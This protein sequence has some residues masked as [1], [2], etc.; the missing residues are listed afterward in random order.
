MQSRR[1][2]EEEEEER[3]DGVAA[4]KAMVEKGRGREGGRKP[5]Y[6]SLLM[7]KALPCQGGGFTELPLCPVQN[8][9][10]PLGLW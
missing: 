8:E 3:Q 9:I 5:L 10:P 2:E 6:G 7:D 4:A 1:K